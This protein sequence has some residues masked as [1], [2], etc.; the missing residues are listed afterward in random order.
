MDL[1][2]APHGYTRIGK[3]VT[4]LLL[5]AAGY[6]GAAFVPPA[7]AYYRESGVAP[8]VCLANCWSRRHRKLE[9]PSAMRF[10]PAVVE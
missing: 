1:R 5:L 2:H 7:S 9:E 4:L 10:P 3:H 8:K 6:C